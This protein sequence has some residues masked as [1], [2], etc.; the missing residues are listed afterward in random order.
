M[1]T[2]SVAWPIHQCVVLSVCPC[3]QWLRRLLFLVYHT[4]WMIHVSY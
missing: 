3:I 1:L 4:I 2:V